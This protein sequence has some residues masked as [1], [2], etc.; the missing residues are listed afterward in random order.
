MNANANQ[1]KLTS[2]ANQIISPSEL[3]LSDNTQLILGVM[4]LGNGGDKSRD[5]S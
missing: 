1:S 4:G 3:S 5:T 2:A